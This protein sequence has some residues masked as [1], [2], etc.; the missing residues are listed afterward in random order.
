MDFLSYRSHCYG[1]LSGV[2]SNLL[3]LTGSNFLHPCF[4]KDFERGN[5]VSTHRLINN[6]TATGAGIVWEEPQTSVTKLSHINY[7]LFFVLEYS[8]SQDY[9]AKAD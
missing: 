3:L 9:L 5:G 8:A 7:K 4:L 2:S 6:C 1:R